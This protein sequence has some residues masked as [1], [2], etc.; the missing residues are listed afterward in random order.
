MSV[1]KKELERIKSLQIG[2]TCLKCKVG[3][4]VK[5]GSVFCDNCGEDAFK[6]QY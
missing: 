3:K 1:D 2:K 5:F 6:K 4:Y